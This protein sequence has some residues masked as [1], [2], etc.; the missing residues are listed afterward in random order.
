MKEEDLEDLE[1]KLA[2]FE[3]APPYNMSE[4]EQRMQS[5]ATAMFR[6]VSRR[7]PVKE[8]QDLAEALETFPVS[9]DAKRSLVEICNELTELI[10]KSDYDSEE[11][12]ED[13][14]SDLKTDFYSILQAELEKLTNEKR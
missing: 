6:V 1:E 9:D 13:R 11:D 12:A 14:I 8:P 5:L 4:V 7:K 3:A 10:E 2:D